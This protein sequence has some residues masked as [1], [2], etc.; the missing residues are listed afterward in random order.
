MKIIATI[1]PANL[2]ENLMFC[3]NQKQESNSQ[4]VRGLV[5]RNIPGFC[6]Y[7]VA[8]YFKNMPNSTDLHKRIFLDV[9]LIV[10]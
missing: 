7:Q 8:H 10:L 4:Q 5:T 6:L 3:R 9:F 1:I 2:V